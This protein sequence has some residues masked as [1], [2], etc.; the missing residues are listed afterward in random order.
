MRNLRKST[1]LSIAATTSA[2]L[3][4]WQTKPLLPEISNAEQVEQQKAIEEYNKNVDKRNATRLKTIGRPWDRLFAESCEAVNHNFFL[5]SLVSGCLHPAS[6]HIQE[7]NTDKRVILNFLP[8]ALSL[9]PR[10][11]PPQGRGAHHCL[12]RVQLGL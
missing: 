4:L 11:V 3:D 5:S 2:P 7:R 10:F 1:V 6:F 9:G 8:T 12:V